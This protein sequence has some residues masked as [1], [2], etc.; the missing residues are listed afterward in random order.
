MVSQYYTGTI[1][2][3]WAN[4]AATLFDKEDAKIICQADASTG[5]ASEPTAPDRNLSLSVTLRGPRVREPRPRV[6]RPSAAFP[7]ARAA[8]TSYRAPISLS[9]LEGGVGRHRSRSDRRWRRAG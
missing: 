1:S 6:C 9:T 4:T 3:P 7:P 5:T 8:K 2:R